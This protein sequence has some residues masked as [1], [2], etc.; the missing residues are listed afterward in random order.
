MSTKSGGAAAA[1]AQQD[2]SSGDDKISQLER[3]VAEQQ[4]TIMALTEKLGQLST[5]R[6]DDG[7]PKEVNIHPPD[8]D[9][10][11]L[12]RQQKLRQKMEELDRAKQ[13]ALDA[14]A[15][16]PQKF[17]CK[18]V[19]SDDPERVLNPAR[20]V[21]AS[22]KSEAEAKYREYFGIKTYGSQ[23]AF[24]IEEHGGGSQK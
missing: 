24:V 9:K 12:K 23:V 4:E 6:G 11:R 3:M 8:P 13:A 5:V 21:G 18:I 14:L 22:S 2:S 7:S 10:E 20:I 16:G 15:D 1:K 19:K 17:L